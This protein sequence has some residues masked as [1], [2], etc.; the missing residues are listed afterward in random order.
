MN[1][2]NFFKQHRALS[3]LTGQRRETFLCISKLLLAQPQRLMSKR[4][5]R[6]AALEHPVYEVPAAPQTYSDHLRKF[7]QLG[8][9]IEDPTDNQVVQLTQLGVDYR[10]VLIEWMG[11]LT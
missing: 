11:R 9:L 6:G 5:L 4:E 2:E 3:T 7:I 8:L 10:K 1:V